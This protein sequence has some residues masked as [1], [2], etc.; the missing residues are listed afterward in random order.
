M[1]RHGL[2]RFLVIDFAVLLG[3]GKPFKV[4]S[5]YGMVS[6]L[7]FAWDFIFTLLFILIHDDAWNDKRPTVLALAVYWYYY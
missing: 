3:Y 7:S 1:A 4:L 6:T 2:A 5:V